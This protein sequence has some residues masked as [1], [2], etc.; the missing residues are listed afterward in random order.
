MYL[1]QDMIISSIQNEHY[2]QNNYKIILAHYR[3]FFMVADDH[4]LMFSVCIYTT[5]KEKLFKNILF[6]IYLGSV[7]CIYLHFP[8]IFRTCHI[9]ALSSQCTKDSSYN[10]VVCTKH[11]RKL[12]KRKI[13]H[14]TFNYATTH[15]YSTSTSVHA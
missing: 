10:S 12:P 2:W 9:L 5:I 1:E 8:P 14:Y 6:S 13:Q 3:Y 7:I 11:V 15:Y 4:T